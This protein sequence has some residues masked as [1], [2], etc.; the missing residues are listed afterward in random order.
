MR[1]RLSR[2]QVVRVPPLG[3]REAPEPA[4]ARTINGPWPASRSERNQGLSRLLGLLV[5]LSLGF[6][7]ATALAGRAERISF[8]EMEFIAYWVDL[9]QDDLALCWRDAAGQPLASFTRLREHFSAQARELT[10]AIN[11]G[12]YSSDDVPLGLHIEASRVLRD[13]NLGGQEGGQFNFYLKPNGVFYVATNRA[14]IA[15]SGQYARLRSHPTLACQSGPL[16]LLDGKIHPAF[17]PE[18]T[19]YRTRTG[20]GLVKDNQV[21]FAISK[22]ALR[23]Y[24]FARLFKER[25]GCRD[26]LYLDGEICA[27]YLPELGLRT[28]ESRGRFVGMFAV[29]T[30]AQPKPAAARSS[31]AR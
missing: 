28:D 5:G 30:K 19:N 29:T 21:V 2:N 26:A 31:E 8:L 1:T 20:V 9:E 3:G 10:F 18:S 4:K 7:A 22:K 14:G 13:L 16:L 24:D 23:F 15:E 25:L 12:I 17:R 6:A 11:A 27:V